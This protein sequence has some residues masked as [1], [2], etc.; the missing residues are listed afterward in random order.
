MAVNCHLK[1]LA[2]RKT[3]GDQNKIAGTYN[4]IGICFKDL[5]AYEIA[6]KFLDSSR[7]MKVKINSSTL[8]NTLISI[9]NVYFDNGQ[10]N[11]SKKLYSQVSQIETAKNN[12]K[13]LALALRN[14]GN[15]YLRLGLLDSARLSF[16]RSLQISIEQG[17][18]LNQ[19]YS[20]LC[21]GRLYIES[22]HSWKAFDYLEVSRKTFKRLND[23]L[24]LAM[25]VSNIGD[26][27]SKI[28]SRDSALRQ[29]Q[30]ALA[31]MS[32]HF[33]ASLSLDLLTRI[34]DIYNTKR[35]S[36]SIFC[37]YIDLT[38]AQEILTHEQT[39]KHLA[40]FKILH[41]VEKI[42]LDKITAQRERDLEKRKSM[43]TAIL[44]VASIAIAILITILFRQR[45]KTKNQLASKNEELH[46]RKLEE[47]IKEQE[48]EKI[49][50]LMEGQEKERKR[51]SGELHDGLGSLLATVKHHF[52]VVEDKMDT[53]KE[54]YVKAYG[55]LDQASEEVRRISHNMAS[56]VLS[57]FGLVAA[58]QDL[59]E[60]LNAS[61][62]QKIELK[63]T[64][65][66]GRLE[67]STEI[68]LFRI[69]QELVSNALKHAK[70]SVISLQITMRAD[71]LSLIIEDNGV[72]F[73]PEEAQQSTG[74]GLENLKARVAH[75]GGTM[76]IDSVIGRGTAFV[77]EVPV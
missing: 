17:D 63:V 67:N 74:M 54:S 76:D 9:A 38:I 52:E 23:T 62:K 19:A 8:T 2:S 1:A 22:V 28:G 24:A 32:S 51:I 60:M 25:C 36:D 44:L 10:F 6:L 73:K 40:R 50:K 69:C 75:L 53:N 21:M 65:L 26:G 29:Y 58:L 72:G 12:S 45:L 56:N 4:N 66:E 39:A 55:L 3:E 61:K 41:N 7:T 35:L 37:T 13:A 47:L 30:K 68:H 71:V 16:K 59:C 42:T 27:F 14:L 34:L 11:Y 5:G 49:T 77:I 20:N 48:L 43:I 46:Q 18:S 15:N 33:D 64:G 70:A 31:L 57:K